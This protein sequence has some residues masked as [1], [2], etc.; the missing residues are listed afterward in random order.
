MT[1]VKI[2]NIV[3]IPVKASAGEH[4]CKFLKK[5]TTTQTRCSEADSTPR[6]RACTPP[7]PVGDCPASG[8]QKDNSRGCC[9]NSY[10]AA[11]AD[12]STSRA[13]D[14]SA[15]PTRKTKSFDGLHTGANSEQ[16][17]TLNKSIYDKFSPIGPLNRSERC[18]ELSNS[19]WNSS[20]V[21]RADVK[22]QKADD[23]WN[24]DV[25]DY[26]EFCSSY[27]EK[28]CCTS[29][30]TTAP[31]AAAAAAAV[32]AAD[33]SRSHAAP[34]PNRSSDDGCCLD[35]SREL[36]SAGTNATAC[37]SSET[38]STLTTDSSVCSDKQRRSTSGFGSMPHD[39]GTGRDLNTSIKKTL[40]E[41]LN[42][43]NTGI[44]CPFEDP[45]A[46]VR[47]ERNKTQNIEDCSMVNISTDWEDD[48]SCASSPN[49]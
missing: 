42:Y 35:W 44:Q 36:N 41:G 33:L 16:K 47:S 26:S 6:K 38:L 2:E 23:S 21:R 7:P 1:G 39:G 22:V 25:S 14:R 37:G 34:T 4:Q 29:E 46:S 49:R 30:R 19:A 24:P 8:K 32:V 11:G 13:T 15:H 20:G 3:P 12:S 27:D 40:P 5:T 31:A 28:S 10:S 9:N 48:E 45:N 43:T 18:G 17:R